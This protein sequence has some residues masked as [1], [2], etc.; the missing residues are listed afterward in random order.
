MAAGLVLDYLCGLGFLDTQLAELDNTDLS[1]RLAHEGGE[2]QGVCVDSGHPGVRARR[3][4]HILD[5]GGRDPAY[6]IYDTEAAARE[7]MGIFLPRP[8]PV[9]RLR[10]PETASGMETSPSVGVVAHRPLTQ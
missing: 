7:A 5:A 1:K 2:H 9:K 8:A 6:E 10:R 3:V 4:R